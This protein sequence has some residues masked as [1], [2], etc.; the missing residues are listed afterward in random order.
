M[1]NNVT[2]PFKLK[3]L[4]RLYKEQRRQIRE[5][6]KETI[7]DIIT[8]QSNEETL[9]S[10]LINEFSE[11]EALMRILFGLS[12]FDPAFISHETCERVLN[13]FELKL[14]YERGEELPIDILREQYLIGN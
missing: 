5:T 10:L 4:V 11:K 7:I 3:I 13:D 14:V 9:V 6:N 12:F 1:P 2:T 8:Q